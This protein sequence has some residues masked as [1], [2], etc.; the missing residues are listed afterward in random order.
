MT[1]NE[2]AIFDAIPN[3]PAGATFKPVKVGTVSLPHPFGT[4]DP[5]LAGNLMFSGMV[6]GLCVTLTGRKRHTRLL[7]VC[8]SAVALT[9]MF[10]CVVQTN[11]GR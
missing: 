11:G 5:G 1:E 9:M 6:F 3:A 4:I 10:V 8:I 7:G 2:Q